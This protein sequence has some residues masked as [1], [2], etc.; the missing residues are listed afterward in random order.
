MKEDLNAIIKKRKIKVPDEPSDL[1]PW[2]RYGLH[3]QAESAVSIP[4][5]QPSGRWTREMR[6]AVVYSALCGIYR[7]NK[8]KAAKV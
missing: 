3:Q 4:K 8:R 2:E 7:L 5:G 1:E 6:V